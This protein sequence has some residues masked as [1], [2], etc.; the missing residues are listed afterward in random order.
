MHLFKYFFILFSFGLILNSCQKEISISTKLEGEWRVVTK[1]YKNFTIDFSNGLSFD[2]YTN[3]ED[4]RSYIYFKNIQENK[5][6]YYSKSS[7][8][9][10]VYE[11]LNFPLSEVL[12][13]FD[14]SKEYNFSIEND[15]NIRIQFDNKDVVYNISQLNSKH[16]ILE[17][18][19]YKEIL[20][21]RKQ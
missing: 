19:D 21:L 3:P 17:N 1:E 4:F 20:T 18:I 8:T 6:N 15:T 11:S 9:K 10:V 16:L 12:D 2:D 5:G 7:K 13:E 14:V